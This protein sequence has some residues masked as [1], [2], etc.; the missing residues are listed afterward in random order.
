MSFGKIRMIVSVMLVLSI[1]LLTACQSKKAPAT[2]SQPPKET[3]SNEQSAAPK[4][5]SQEAI[6]PLGKFDP[7]I[8]MVG[9]RYSNDQEYPQGESLDNNRWLDAYRST[10][11]IE[12]KW[13]F[14]T[15]GA[16]YSEKLS[17]AIAS[18]DIPDAMVVD[19]T[20]FQSLLDNDMLE[21][22]TEV[23]D[24]Y[25][26]KTTKAALSE[27]STG[28]AA[29]E[30]A[31]RSGKL[32]GIPETAQTVAE[33][34]RMLFVRA[35]WLDK[36]NLPEPKTI[37]DVIKI[38]EAFATLDPDGNNVQDTYGLAVAKSFLFA[39]FGDLSGFFNGYHADPNIWLKDASGNLV[40]GVIQ[41]EMKTALQELQNM[42]SKGILSTDMAVN[43][44]ES[45]W[46][47]AINGKLGMSYGVIWTP[48]QPLNLNIEADPEADWK[49]F[50]I[51]SADDKPAKVRGGSP[52]G[53]YYV[54]KKGYSN[55]EA[56]VKMANLF[57]ENLYNIPNSKLIT[58]KK[59]DGTDGTISLVGLALVQAFN[60]DSSVKTA[61]LLSEALKAKDPSKLDKGLKGSYDLALKFPQDR[62]AWLTYRLY[63][64]E[65]GSYNV[66]N[67]Y[68][69]NDL[70]LLNAYGGPPT[71]T[72]ISNN[73]I[74][75]DLQTDIFTKIIMGEAHIDEFDSF[76]EQWK[77]SG[78]EQ[79]TK[80][81]N[82]WYAANN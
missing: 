53:D 14:M 32:Y 40:H 3:A 50:P 68:D 81:V 65:Y 19:A 11:G 74:L 47:A 80:E 54:V 76:V 38:A 69:K 23:Y 78:G 12:L 59:G 77:K 21:D 79:M 15:T 49:A 75:R 60:P 33:K 72:M 31:S 43:T 55:P 5:T 67:Y 61:T 37:Q 28:K 16:E 20:T 2:E 18:N 41:P 29:L 30:M 8:K 39:D 42:F 56:I 66:A 73:K 62:K 17:V 51:V 9:A 44:V 35:D 57:I 63:G 34:A 4:E 64:D 6:D 58:D 26:S 7:P 25:A 10:L 70:L 71:P 48:A 13:K 45:E 22:L 27:T 52:T 24:K 36:L 46:D 1:V 82:E